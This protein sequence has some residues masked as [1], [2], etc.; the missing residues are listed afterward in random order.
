MSND[1]TT[2]RLNTIPDLSS[3]SSSQTTTTSSGSPLYDKRVRISMLDNSPAIFYKDTSNSLLYTYLYPTNGVLFPFQPKVDIS[4]SASYQSQKVIQSNFLFH[5]YENSEIKSI[6]LTC[7]FPARNITEGQY[8]IAAITFLRSL[9]FMFTGM[10]NTNATGSASVDLSGAPPLIVSI[11]GMGFGGLDYIPVVITN[12]TSSYSDNIDYISIN[13]PGV[14]AV[15]GE[16]IKVPTSTTISISCLPI[17][18]R[19]LASQFSTIA[20]SKGYFRLIGPN[21][22]INPSD[23]TTE[24]T[25][26][27]SGQ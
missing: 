20:F 22:F 6:D 23:Y 1:A 14:D 12:V 8:V 3:V 25:T 4:F 5:S 9:T 18:S 11:R 2:S 10:D 19:T 27:S 16:I 15:E 26:F 13:M 7:D 24:N 21:G 17:F